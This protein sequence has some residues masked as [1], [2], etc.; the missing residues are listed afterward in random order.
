MGNSLGPLLLDY[1]PDQELAGRHYV[2][3]SLGPHYFLTYQPFWLEPKV[4]TFLELVL[5]Y[6]SLGRWATQFS[7][8][9]TV[10]QQVENVFLFFQLPRLFKWIVRPLSFLLS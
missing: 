1:R 7:T 8:I 3:F 2:P 5:A 6:L 4:A 10:V 9:K